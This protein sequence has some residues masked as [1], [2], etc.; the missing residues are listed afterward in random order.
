MLAARPVSLSFA[1]THGGPWI[2]IA[3]GLENTGR[4]AWPI[5]MPNAAESL[6]AAGGAGRGGQHRRK[7]DARPGHHRPVATHDSCS[8]RAS[9]GRKQCAARGAVLG[10]L[11]ATSSA[12][13]AKPQAVYVGVAVVLVSGWQLNC[14]PNKGFILHPSRPSPPAPRP[15]ILTAWP[16][17]PSLL[18]TISPSR[19]NTRRSRSAQSLATS[20]SCAGRRFSAC[21]RPC[22]GG[23][24]GDF[25]LKTFEGR[26][27]LFRDVHEVLSTVAMFGGGRRLAVVEDADDFVTRYR[28]QLEDY[29]ARPSRS[30]VLVLDLD[31]LPSNTRLYKSIAARRPVDRL[32]APRRHGL[33]KWLGDWAKQHHDVRTSPGGRRDAGRTDRAGTRAARPGIGQAGAGGRRGAE[34]H[35]RT[36]PA[37]RWAAGGPK[38]LGTCSTPLWTATSARPC[39]NSIA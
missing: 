13:R 1:E 31:S 26:E 21:G 23:D 14:H 19:A 11:S 17:S 22:L 6:F 39:C 10:E 2:P 29:V 33:T 37:V 36:G 16:E 4:Y 3:S 5:D 20:R 24:D 15:S 34:D 28:G 35:A 38:P 12:M 30:G 8:R 32:R 27:A 18:S 7:R 9:G 25:S